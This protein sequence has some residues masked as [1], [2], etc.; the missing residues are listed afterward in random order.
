MNE[1]SKINKAFGKKSKFGINKKLNTI[2]IILILLIMFSS[3]LNFKKDV[4]ERFISY[5]KSLLDS[6]KLRF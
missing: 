4:N 1:E 6:L 3:Y 5:S 2:F